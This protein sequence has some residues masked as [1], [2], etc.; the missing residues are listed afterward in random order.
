MV[1]QASNELL[2]SMAAIARAAGGRLLAVYSPTSRP[3]SRDDMFGAGQRNE[4]VS[5]Q[6]MRDALTALRPA[7]GWVDEDQETTELPDGEWWTVDA[8]EGNVNNVHGMSD[9]CVVI[10][11]IRNGVPVATTIYQPVGDLLYTASQGGGAFLNGTPLRVSDKSQFNAA[12][13]ATGQAEA[14]Q[15]NTPRRIGNS[16]TAM[17]HKA[18]LVR[19]TVPSTFPMILVASG[20]NDVFWQYEPVLPGVAAGI[21]LV[22]EAGGRATRIDGSPWRPGAADILVATP[23]L[24][25]EAVQT[26]ANI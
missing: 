1:E 12:I 14:D 10:T 3:R 23:G 6:G 17:L 18:L 26:L 21:L 22:T 24:F 16:I 25:A 20:H 2:D 9:W 8:V 11:L 7:A 15:Q 5:L 19:A 4:E 13:V